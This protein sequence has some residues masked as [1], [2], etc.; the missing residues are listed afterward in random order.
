MKRRKRSKEAIKLGSLLTEI[1]KEYDD[2][3][4]YE[5]QLFDRFFAQVTGYFSTLGKTMGLQPQ[6]VEDIA[7]NALLNILKSIVSKM[8][9]FDAAKGSITTWLRMLFNR[10]RQDFYRSSPR[11]L[12]CQELLDQQEYVRAE[13]SPLDKMIFFESVEISQQT[14]DKLSFPYAFVW[15]KMLLENNLVEMGQDIDLSKSQLCKIRNRI[16]E[17]LDVFFL[18]A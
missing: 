3:G 8:N 4:F 13:F 12:C 6:D 1:Y 17:M 18:S 10:R 15:K 14:M 2:T 16:R 9:R 11:D 7:Q 5:N